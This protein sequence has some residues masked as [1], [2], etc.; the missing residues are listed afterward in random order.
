M[1]RGKP[2]RGSVLF[3][4]FHALYVWNVL[5]KYI[6]Y[7]SLSS[8]FCSFT[9]PFSFHFLYP[10][11]SSSRYCWLLRTAHHHSHSFP[12]HTVPQ[13]AAESILATA[14]PSCSR[15]LRRPTQLL[16]DHKCRTRVPK[17][18]RRATSKCSTYS[19]SNPQ[20]IITQFIFPEMP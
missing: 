9:A 12:P 14:A 5:I 13:P 6:L 7:V 1:H 20:L 16:P 3:F 8:Q 19:T 15:S 17:R 18:S 10:I 2:S 11:L 4:L